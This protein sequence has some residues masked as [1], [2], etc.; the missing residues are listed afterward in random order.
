M[1]SIYDYPDVYDAVLRAPSDQIVAE[2]ESIVG[3]LGARGITGGRVLDV[4]CGT[5]AHGILLAKRGFAV[6]GADISPRMLEGARQGAKAAGAPIDLV[7]ADWLSLDL[8]A[9]G[10]D[11]AIFMAETFPLI[12]G[13]DELRSHFAAVRRLLRPGG[14]YIVDVDTPRH[15]VGTEYGVWGER[16]VAIPGGSVQIWHEDFPG[17]WVNAIGHLRMH[18]RI[19]R[20]GETIETSDDWLIRKDSPWHL[21]L[22]VRTLPGWRLAGFY[23]WRD[24]SPDI[25]PEQHYFMVLE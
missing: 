20:A 3:L 19:E 7:Q 24:L 1:A 9:A 6:T 13:Y 10:F 14:L 17:D 16:T 2:V 11:C 5:C 22:L 15:G 25:A 18:C 8:P 21:T 4:A 23:S 12:T